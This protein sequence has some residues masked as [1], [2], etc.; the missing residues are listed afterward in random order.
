MHKSDK[1]RWVIESMTVRQ[2]MEDVINKKTKVRV[3]THNF[4]FEHSNLPC[5]MLLNKLHNFYYLKL[6]VTS[7]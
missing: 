4:V 5:G 1:I 7:I 6:Y 3:E 2:A